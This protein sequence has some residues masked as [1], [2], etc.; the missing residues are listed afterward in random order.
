MNVV[1]VLI[2]NICIVTGIVLLIR[3]LLRIFRTR[4]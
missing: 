4:K 3:K 1:L 2:C